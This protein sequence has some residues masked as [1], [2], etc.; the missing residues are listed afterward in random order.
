[1]T[2][3]FVVLCSVLVPLGVV[4]AWTATILDD[5]DTYVETVEPLATD[6][7]VTTVVAE[8]LSAAALRAIGAPANTRPE[9]QT[10]VRAAAAA[11]ITSRQFPKVWATANRVV[12]REA[13]KLLSGETLPPGATVQ[14]NLAPMATQVSQELA[15]RGV[16]VNLSNTD[17]SVELAATDELEKART[18][19]RIVQAAGYWVP[20]AAGLL[21]V[22]TLLTA[23]QRLAT[24][25]HL[26]VGVA[27][28]LLV[29]RAGLAV[30]GNVVHEEVNDPGGVIWETVTKS[31]GETLV[32]G[33]VISAVILAI[34]IAIGMGRGVARRDA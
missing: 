2:W 3:L 13:V 19:W 27:L 12:H 34:R 11:A 8:E 31:L 29:T 22:I 23:R 10:H 33:I 30:A 17:L 4:S 24:L 21:L 5:T 6:S 15:D 28:M 14:I 1:M 26:A 9:V 16:R 25:G 18:G 32:I 20:I 7:D